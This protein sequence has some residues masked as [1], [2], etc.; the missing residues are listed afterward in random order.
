[1]SR[2]DTLM[3]MTEPGA[4]PDLPGRGEEPGQRDARARWDAAAAAVLRKAGRLKDDAS[5][6]AAWARLARTTVEG[7][8]IPPLGTA[9]D[10]AALPTAAAL[11]AS[12]GQAP[13]LR[14]STSAGAWDVR[15]L[16]DVPDAAN[17]NAAAL[18][19]LSG[20]GN[21]LWIRV[22]AGGVPVGDLAAALDGVRLDLAPVV[23]DGADDDI[24][25]AADV[26]DALVTAGTAP[27]SETEA[28]D[29]A[30]DDAPAPDASSAAGTPAS[31][32]I[33]LDISDVRRLA[34]G[35][36]LGADPLGRALR[37][38]TRNADLGRVPDIAARA[39]ALGIG[40]LVVDGTAVHEAGAG[41]AQE[42]GYTLAAGVAYLRELTAAGY[43]IDAACGLVSFRYAVTD[44]QFGSIAK[45]R[46]ARLTWHRLAQLSGASAPARVQRQHAVTSTAMMTRYDRYVNLLR[47]TVAAFAAGVGGARSVTVLPFAEPDEFSRRMAR[48]ISVLLT[49]ESQVDAVADPAGGAYAVERL[50]GELAEA[51]WAEFGRIEAS[52]GVVAALAD[53]SLAARIADTRAERDRRIA[54]RSWPITG[55]S[56][57]PLAGEQPTRPAQAAQ[58][59]WN[60]YRWAAPFE[61]LRDTPPPAPLALVRLGT[62][63]HS[64]A[65]FSF[66]ENLLIAGGLPLCVVSG[67]EQPA[68]GTAV[69][70]RGIAGSAAAGVAH[71][72]DEVGAAATHTTASGTG[73]GLTAT[74]R[75]TGCPAVIFAG[76]DADYAA[77]LPGAVAAA[78]EAGARAV[79]LAGRPKTLA[80]DGLVDGTVAAG[81]DVL[82]FLATVRAAL[83][84]TAGDPAPTDAATTGGAR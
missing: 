44:D 63:A 65:R 12:P 15:T 35:S 62:Q 73:D 68:D 13:Y 10:A 81:D 21:S 6:A 57:F 64:A 61:A 41:D 24:L 32:P 33:P 25:A 53:G 79:F 46:A 36:G 4:S 50:T 39:T 20:G 69:G 14:G 78:R 56:E 54:K 37:S 38:S 77:L 55:V 58:A 19:D 80:T 26:L 52:G 17:A 84:A 51:A 31:Q 75:E 22:G 28:S 49:G 47:C 27:S 18:A 70:A 23:L 82:A 59:A 60:G 66:A 72:A 3:A 48:N 8:T 67:P 34:P 2:L 5:D 74:I 71:G 40:A 16:I 43:D 45:L 11:A 42:V 83:G 29:R 1:M 9:D 76:S 30:A 7:L